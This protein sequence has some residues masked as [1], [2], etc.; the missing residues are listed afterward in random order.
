MDLKLRLQELLKE[1]KKRN[2]EEAFAERGYLEQVKKFHAPVVREIQEIKKQQT[3]DQ[4][5]PEEVTEPVITER[6]EHFDEGLEP[7][8]LGELPMPSTIVVNNQ[9][10]EIPRLDDHAAQIYRRLRATK[11]GLSKNTSA[12]MDK[13]DEVSHQI[14]Q[15][16]TYRQRL[17]DIKEVMRLHKTY[18]Q[19]KGFNK[20]PYII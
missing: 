7:D 11:G 10:D 5:V 20:K 3:E 1:R 17:K 12:N 4:L 9:L 2:E 6:L 13:I 18:R 15:F 14:D 8:I 19:G 16:I